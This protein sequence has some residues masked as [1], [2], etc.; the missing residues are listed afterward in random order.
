MRRRFANAW[1]VLVAVGCAGVGGSGASSS[2]TAPAASSAP[3]SPWTV[4]TSYVLDLW[5]HG[6]AM[7]QR[8]TTQVPFFRR[9]YRQMIASAKSSGGVSTQLDANA[10]ALQRG[11]DAN[12]GLVS[13]QFLGLQERTWEEMQADIAAF[14]DAN[15]DPAAARD[16]TM[17][18]A[19][20]AYAQSYPDKPARDMAAP[21]CAVAGGRA[22]T[23][24]PAVLEQS[25]AGARSRTRP[26]GLALHESLLPAIA[27]IS[28]QRATGRGEILLSLPL[29]GEGRTITSGQS[30]IAVEFPARP[31][32]AIEAVYVFVHEALGPHPGRPCR[33]TRRRTRNRLVLHPDIRARRQC[34]PVRCSF[35]VR[36]P[37]WFPVTSDSTSERR[38][39][40][41]ARRTSTVS[42]RARSRFRR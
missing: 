15:G 16:S 11:L 28:E 4:K 14:L 40:A 3:V 34:A 22:H 29:D 18:P 21:L 32:S 39:A 2:D 33:I 9:G 5:L 10:A 30:A 7:V 24:L 8:D 19:I 6:Y 12:P 31:D 1:V 20:A 35:A 38:A 23:L 27:R 37:I 41:V 42:S 17:R 36:F 26:R 13:G 25:P